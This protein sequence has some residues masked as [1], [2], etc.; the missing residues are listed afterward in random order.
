MTWNFSQTLIRS[1]LGIA[2]GLGIALAPSLAHADEDDG[3]PHIAVEYDGS[4]TLELEFEVL[5]PEPAS[6][7]PLITVVTP[8]VSSVSSPPAPGSSEFRTDPVTN[9]FFNTYINDDLGFVSEGVASGADITIQLTAANLSPE[10]KGFAVTFG[11]Q[12][13]VAVNDSL[14]LG[15]TFDAHPFWTIFTD[16]PGDIAS[17]ELTFDLFDANNA[18]SPV[19]SFAVLVSNDLAADGALVPE[20]GTAA[21]AVAGGALLMFRR[22]RTA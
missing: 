13:I 2:A 12:S 14:S 4:T 17:A 22:R 15:D 1:G 18:S 21:L 7:P 8:D 10:A 20:P 16:N 5:A 11:A 19:E 3:A 6:D 9:G